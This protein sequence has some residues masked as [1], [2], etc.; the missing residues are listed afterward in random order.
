MK[1]RI[2][3]ALICLPLFFVV[4]F[5]LE[6]PVFTAVLSLLLAIGV[7]EL[8]QTA[9]YGKKKIIT[10]NCMIFGAWIFRRRNLYE[11]GFVGP[12][13]KATGNHV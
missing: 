12:L 1:T 8:L 2:I 7:H 13:F 6:T 9:Q 11:S 10:A 3:T 4:F 5:L